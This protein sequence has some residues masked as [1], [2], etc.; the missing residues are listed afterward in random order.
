MRKKIRVE[1]W[2]LKG[3]Q[4]PRWYQVGKATTMRGAERIARRE[5]A[6]ETFGGFRHPDGGPN[7]GAMR[8]VMPDDRRLYWNGEFFQDPEMEEIKM[9]K[10]DRFRELA[11]RVLNSGQGLDIEGGPEILGAAYKRSGPDGRGYYIN[12]Q[13]K[14]WIKIGGNFEG[15]LHYLLES[16][17]QIIQLHKKLLEG[18]SPHSYCTDYSD[19]ELA[20]D[21][22]QAILAGREGVQSE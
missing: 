8:A 1:M 11:F 5:Y 12:N 13:K 9:L 2:R 20:L 22:I 10:G 14:G 7:Y 16:G 6:P 15:A 4:T 19:L 17:Q 18:D 21:E 3:D